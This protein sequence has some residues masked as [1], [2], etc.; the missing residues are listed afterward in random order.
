MPGLAAA[1]FDKEGVS[2]TNAYGWANIEEN[3]AATPDTLF[4]LASISKLVTATA[5]MQLVEKGRL[6]LDAD[7]NA[8]LPFEINNPFCPETAITARML[9]THTASLLDNNRIYESL[10]SWGADSSISLAELLEGFYTPNGRWFKDAQCFL[11]KCPGAQFSYSNLGFALIAYLVE[12]IT[13]QPFDAYCNENIFTPLK[14]T[15]TRWFLKDLD[16]T[17]IAMPYQDTS[18]LGCVRY[19]PYG[20]YGYPDYPSGQIRSSAPQFARF[21]CAF[22]NQGALEGAVILQPATVQQMFTVQFPDIAPYQ[23]LGW[24]RLIL[25]DGSVLLGHGG[26]EHGVLN[27]AWFRPEDSAGVIVFSSGDPNDWAIWRSQKRVE[28]ITAIQ[29]R[30]FEDQ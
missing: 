15:E 18:F 12:C 17:H 22:M 1:I 2:W 21:F 20:Q 8:Y 24:I 4:Q 19:K 6:D 11:K 14:M 25:D 23:G 10:Y 5:A 3:R 13:A 26:G 27:M 28:A 9:L 29:N 16:P 7:I 30:L